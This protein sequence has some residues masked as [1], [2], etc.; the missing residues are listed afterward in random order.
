VK[1]EVNFLIKPVNMLTLPL[2]ETGENENLLSLFG[3]H[4]VD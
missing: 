4:L 3:S 1:T 2:A